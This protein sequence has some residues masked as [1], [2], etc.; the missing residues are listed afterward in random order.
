MAA[1][2]CA[3]CGTTSTSAQDYGCEQ[4][5]S[6]RLDRLDLAAR[7]RLKSYA[8][9]HRADPPYTTV[10]VVLDAGPVVRALA[11]EPLTA[12]IGDAVAA[13]GRAANGRLLFAAEIP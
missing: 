4:C 9:I 13:T 1:V 8:T 12:A 6:S 11:Q 5:G 3:A 2:R 10:D 7:G